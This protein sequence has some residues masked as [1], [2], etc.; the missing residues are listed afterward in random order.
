MKIIIALSALLLSPI[1]EAQADATKSDVEVTLMAIGD[2]SGGKL[3]ANSTGCAVVHF[4]NRTK[5]PIDF[6]TAPRCLGKGR[7]KDWNDASYLS[8]KQREGY[9]WGYR[10]AYDL[11]K[12]RIEFVADDGKV[13]HTDS[14]IQLQRIGV[15]DAEVWGFSPILFFTPSQ[16]GV[17][18]VRFYFDNTVMRQLSGHNSIDAILG[19]QPK[20]VTIND[21]VDIPA[22]P[23]IETKAEQVVPPNGP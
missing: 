1:I 23:V 15:I 13:V 8:P 10:A 22:V 11:P 9:G 6:P 5:E 14:S 17:Y 20:L 12:V 3:Q 2:P 4:L 7:V 18:A 16:A 19:K 21:R